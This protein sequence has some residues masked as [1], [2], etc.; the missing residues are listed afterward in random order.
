MR[1]GG[2]V[3]ENGHTIYY[4][5]LPRNINAAAYAQ[6]GKRAE[7]HELCKYVLDPRVHNHCNERHH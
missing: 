6:L 1:G 2:A 3:P 4:S 7:P 5:F